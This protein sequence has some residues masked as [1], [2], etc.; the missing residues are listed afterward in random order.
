MQNHDHAPLQVAIFSPYPERLAAAIEGSGDRVIVFNDDDPR[1]FRAP[2]DWIV[3]YGYRK[4]ID[5]TAYPTAQGRLVN[6]HISL[7]PWNRGADPNFWSWFDD[8]PKGVTLHHIDKGLDTGAIVAA[9]EVAFDTAAET[10]GSS[11]NR[12]Q[13]EACALFRDV[14]PGLRQGDVPA[15]TQTGA[16]SYHRRAQREAIWDQFPLGW[17]TPVAEIREHGR[18]AR[19]GSA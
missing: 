18:K 15:I 17:D 16:G 8:T 6:L 1:A 19:L 2:A 4:I 11:Y 3:S 14:W 7:L 9:R 13:D 12:L 5:P 10:L